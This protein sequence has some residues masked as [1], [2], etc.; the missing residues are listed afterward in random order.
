MHATAVL[1]RLLKNSTARYLDAEAA[2]A[3][4]FFGLDMARKMSVHPFDV[5]DKVYRIMS[6]LWTS[7]K[8]YRDQNGAPVITLR[9]RWRSAGSHVMDTFAYWKEEF[10]DFEDKGTNQQQTQ[11]GED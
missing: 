5:A 7:E 8:V 3:S 11:E 6:L 1:L 9:V 4:F 10:K 2:K